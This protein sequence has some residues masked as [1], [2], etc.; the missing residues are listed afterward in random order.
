[1]R[2]AGETLALLRDRETSAAEVTSEALAAIDRHNPSLSAFVSVDHERA[3]AAADRADGLVAGGGLPGPLHGLPV[4]IKD[5][6]EATGMP[7]TFGA[8]LHRHNL[9]HRDS[10][11]VERLRAAGAIVV[12]KTNTPALGALGE[13]KNQLGPDCCNPGDARLTAGGSSGGSAAAVAA[14]LV[15]LATG[16]D[17]AGSLS[18]PASFCGVVG[19]KPSR[20]MI[21][22]WPGAGDSLLLTDTGPLTRSVADAA[23][24][25]ATV[26]GPDRRDPISRAGSPPDFV[27]ALE[28]DSSTPLEGARIGLS[29]DLQA[30][31]VDRE[32]AAA[33]TDA[34]ISFEMLGARVEPVSPPFEA[35][36]EIYMPIYITDLR[37]YLER[38][39][40]LEE[41]LFPE[42]LLELQEHPPLGAEDYAGVLN[43]LWHLRAE[44]AALFED[45][46]LL[47]TPA[48]ACPAFPLRQPPERIAD[49]AVKPGWQSFMPFQVPWN[50]TGSPSISVPC[51]SV[52]GDG[53]PI[54]LL[55]AAA[56]GDDSGVLRAA[57][58]FEQASSAS[59]EASRWGLTTTSPGAPA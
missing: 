35:L 10:I 50:L 39:P 20:G 14:G 9:A 7:T 41:E 25:L 28:I 32:V 18:C 3:Q 21:P 49:S 2:T 15:P 47:L 26:A 33:V 16:T 37:R 30:F 59:R 51:A 57:A 11:I 22:Q 19:M 55:L 56:V 29:I 58:A 12:G 44:A 13:T 6:Q 45:F 54:G 38:F 34:A 40:E 46:E 4:A 24:M 23:L 31:P 48:T 36:L 52:A 42:T 1:M 17:S 43:R 8:R 5:V 27:A 53:R